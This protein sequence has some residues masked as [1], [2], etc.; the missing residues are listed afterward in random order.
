MLIELR[1]KFLDWKEQL[2]PKHPI[3]EAIE[4]VLVHREELQVFLADAP[5]PSRKIN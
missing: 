3:A 2:L 1:E 4:Y 5:R